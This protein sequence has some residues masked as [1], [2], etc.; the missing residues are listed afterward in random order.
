M[1]WESGGAF[2]HDEALASPPPL[3][4]PFIAPSRRLI[5]IRRA[6]AVGTGAVLFDLRSTLGGVSG[7]EG[8]KIVRHTGPAGDGG[9]RVDD[10]AGSIKSVALN[11]A[12]D[13]WCE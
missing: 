3:L 10:Y 12:K 13:E 11:L 8:N 5:H 4:I 9:G 6:N 2:L 7:G 1:A